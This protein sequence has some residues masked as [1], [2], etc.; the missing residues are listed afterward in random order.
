M[1]RIFFR[2]KTEQHCEF[3]VSGQKNSHHGTR[4]SEAQ[5]VPFVLKALNRCFVPLQKGRKHISEDVGSQP[6]FIPFHTKTNILLC[7]IFLKRNPLGNICL[8]FSQDGAR[9]CPC[10]DVLLEFTRPLSEPA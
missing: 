10:G 1:A 9:R 4:L 8:D 7:L 5:G 3:F 2:A 6:L